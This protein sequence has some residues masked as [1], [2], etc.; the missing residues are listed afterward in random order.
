MS[1]APLVAPDANM[2]G[3]VSSTSADAD[4]RRVAAPSQAITYALSAEQY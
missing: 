1:S 4:T 2:R 3:R